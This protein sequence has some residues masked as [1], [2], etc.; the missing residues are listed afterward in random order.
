MGCTIVVSQ[1][2]NE[3]ERI[4]AGAARKPSESQH[5]TGR[6]TASAAP[7]RIEFEISRLPPHPGSPTSLTPIQHTQHRILPPAFEMYEEWVA[8]PAAGTIDRDARVSVGAPSCYIRRMTP[9]VKGR[10]VFSLIKPRRKDHSL[11]AR[12]SRIE[13]QYSDDYLVDSAGV[14]PAAAEDVFPDTD[15]FRRRS[16]PQ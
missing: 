14:L 13:N 3:E 9:T 16:H 12:T 2:K 7:P 1:T 15:D 6:R 10:R 5:K 8:L 11:G 4:S